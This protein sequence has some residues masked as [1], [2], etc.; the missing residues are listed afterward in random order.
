[1]TSHTNDLSVLAHEGNADC[2]GD[3][4]LTARFA[5]FYPENSVWNDN[6]I[7]DDMIRMAIESG[8]AEEVAPFGNEN[9]VS[10]QKKIVDRPDEWHIARIIYFI[11]HPEEIKDIWIDNECYHSRYPGMSCILPKPIITDGHHRYRAAAYL[12]LEKSHCEYSGR[13][14][15]LEYLRGDVDECPVE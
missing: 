13:T 14:D 11:N 4:I 8:V 6:P 3:M 2:K 5:E 12:G 7:T 10:E 15:L 1:M 9:V